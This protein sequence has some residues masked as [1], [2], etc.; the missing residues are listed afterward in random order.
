MRVEL[1]FFRDCEEGA[2]Y[3]GVGTLVAA[4]LWDG[5]AG[6]GC[7]PLSLGQGHQFVGCS[8]MP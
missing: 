6:P 3:S 4:S 8:R 5:P 7:R 1:I 2:L